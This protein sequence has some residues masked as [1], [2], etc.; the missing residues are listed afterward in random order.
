MLI[1][2]FLYVSMCILLWLGTVH[3]TL[4]NCKSGNCVR[5]SHNDTVLYRVD[6]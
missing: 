3:I 6:V 2:A 1:Y 4:C 5:T